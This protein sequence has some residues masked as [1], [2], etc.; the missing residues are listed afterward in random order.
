MRLTNELEDMSKNLKENDRKSA[1]KEFQTRL[2]R[3]S[4]RISTKNDKAIDN[5]K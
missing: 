5:I 4:T 2:A 3:I 1:E